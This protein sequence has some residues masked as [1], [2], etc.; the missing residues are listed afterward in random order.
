MGK[1]CRE[2]VVKECCGEV[3]LDGRRSDVV[4]VEVVLE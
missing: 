2:S 1:C 4:S 3:L